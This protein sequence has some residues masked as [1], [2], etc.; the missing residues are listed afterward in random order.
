MVKRRRGIDFGRLKRG[1]FTKK[2]KQRGMSVQ[3]FARTVIANKDKYDDKTVKQAVLARTFK[4]MA[5]KR[6]LKKKR[7]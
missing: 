2:A 6:K 4:R 3:D 5:Q 1:A 7:K